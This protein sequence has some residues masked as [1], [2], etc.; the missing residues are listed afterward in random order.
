M[1]AFRYHVY[2]C[3]RHKPEGVQSCSA[4]GAGHVLEALRREIA[5]PAMNQAGWRSDLEGHA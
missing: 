5:G 3:D 2:V 4:R 1:E